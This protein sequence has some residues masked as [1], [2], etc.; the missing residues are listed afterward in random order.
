MPQCLFPQQKQ[1]LLKA[2]K[3]TQK[4]TTDMEYDKKNGRHT[5]TTTLA[6]CPFID[7][8]GNVN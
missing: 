4:S 3:F 2:L 7:F 1:Q 6:T 8:F 5:M